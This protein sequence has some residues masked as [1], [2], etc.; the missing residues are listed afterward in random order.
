MEPGG[1]NRMLVRAGVKKGPEVVTGTVTVKPRIRGFDRNTY[2]RS[3]GS[4]AIEQV[5][6]AQPPVSVRI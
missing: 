2:T 5:F 6:V 3:G 1:I 4:G